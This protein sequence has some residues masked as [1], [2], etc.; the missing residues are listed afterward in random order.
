MWAIWMAQQTEGS[1]TEGLIS[2]IS[3]TS[4]FKYKKKKFLRLKPTQGGSRTSSHLPSS[5]TLS[6]QVRGQ[7]GFNVNSAVLGDGKISSPGVQVRALGMTRVW[8]TS[9][10]LHSSWLVDLPLLLVIVE[11]FIYHVKM[12]PLSHLQCNSFAVGLYNDFLIIFLPFLRENLFFMKPRFLLAVCRE[13][14]NKHKCRHWKSM[15]ALAVLCRYWNFR[16][17]INLLHDEID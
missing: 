17:L 4:T 2:L 3:L 8:R 9:G 12:F 14:K 10:V 7:L 16:S 1:S 11:S 13:E 6:Y 15:P 5:L